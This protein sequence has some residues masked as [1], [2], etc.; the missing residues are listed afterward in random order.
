[1]R[2]SAIIIL[3]SIMLLAPGAQALQTFSGDVVNI[4][5]PVED[6]VFASGSVVNVNA[7]VDSVVVVG[8]TLTINAPVKGDVFAAG[9]H[10]LVNSQV[11]GKVVAAG[12]TVNLGASIGTNAVAAGGTVNILPG[13]LIKRDVLIVAGNV[14]NAGRINGTL[15]VSA[16]AFQ[17]IGSAGRMVEFQRMEEERSW[18]P[19]DRLSLLGVLTL[20]GFLV[21]GILLLITMPGLFR[22]IDSEIRIS[23]TVRTV[24][25]F[26]LMIASFVAVLVLA[27]TVIGLPLAFVMAMTLVAMLIL[28]GTFV[29]FSL[30]RWV[31]ELA[32]LKAG[33]KA[34]FG[35]GF[36]ILNILFILPY[37]GWLF[38]LIS[39]SLGFGAM[40]YAAYGRRGQAGAPKA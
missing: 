17:N 38:G 37:V 33:D 35:I 2:S 7:P 23:P 3:M 28:T 24:M 34:L 18:Q 4:D 14:N 15:A 31:G 30:G 6:D 29:S 20:V 8:G 32:K 22:A 10:V 12:G 39:M 40:I 13:T 36:V 25:G 9:A 11:G 16:K 21:M 26:L 1:M 19:S 27:I 5:H